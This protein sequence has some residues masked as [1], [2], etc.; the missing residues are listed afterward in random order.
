VCKDW[1]GSRKTSAG[2][3]DLRLY[4]G[5][6]SCGR[7]VIALYSQRF[8]KARC[9]DF[10]DVRFG[11]ALR[12]LPAT[13]NGVTTDKTTIW[14]HLGS[15]VFRSRYAWD[16]FQPQVWCIVFVL[17][18]L[19]TSSF[20]WLWFVGTFWDSGA[21]GTDTLLS[22]FRWTHWIKIRKGLVL[23]IWRQRGVNVYPPWK[24]S[25]DKCTRI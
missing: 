23:R 12:W 5:E 16:T 7:V 11:G 18:R 2:Y 19:A 22:S 9:C 21:S 13:R 1:G 24:S 17:T 4:G 3:E 20:C 8:G 15:A 25:F 10:S 14:I 6:D